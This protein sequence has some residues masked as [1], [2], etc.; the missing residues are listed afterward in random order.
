MVI[1]DGVD[2]PSVFPLALVAS[3][4]RLVGNAFGLPQRRRSCPTDAPTDLDGFW[5]NIND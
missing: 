3:V 1:L 4:L 5:D 2:L